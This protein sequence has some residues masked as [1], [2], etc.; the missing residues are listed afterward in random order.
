MHPGVIGIEEA[1][2]IGGL[3]Q[4]QKLGLIRY[5]NQIHRIL[6]FAD[7]RTLLINCEKRTMPQWVQSDFIA[8]CTY[9]TEEDLVATTAHMDFDSLP[10]EKKK[11]AHK[12]YTMIA[13]ALAFLADDYMRARSIEQAA[14]QHGVTPQTIRKY[15]CLFLVYSDTISVLQRIAYKI[16]PR[17]AWSEG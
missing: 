15:L 16:S 17:S 5:N 3:L 14:Q 10:T 12:R 9:C 4:M 11:L 6:A 1:L 13:P 2:R 7:N 8:N